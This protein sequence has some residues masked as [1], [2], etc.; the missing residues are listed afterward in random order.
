MIKQNVMSVFDI[1]HQNSN[2]TSKIVSGLERTSEAF[3][4]LLWD[5]TKTLGLSPIQIQILIFIKY[6]DIA[7]CNVSALAKEFNL[8]KATV[9][10]AVKALYK[11]QLI[12][13][14]PSDIDKRAYSIVL[15]PKGKEAVITTENFAAPLSEVVD[16]IGINEQIQFFST[17]SK[18]IH[19]LN[20]AGILTVQRSCYNCRFFQKTNGQPYCGLLE[21][22]LLK[23]DIRLDCAEFEAV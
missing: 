21:S 7:L 6:H 1:N 13:K 3:R 15:S 17:L 19:G 10:D 11:K 4:V 23:A 8:T 12:E 14:I 2:L 5:F 20:K 16:S 9:S 22:Q 18:I